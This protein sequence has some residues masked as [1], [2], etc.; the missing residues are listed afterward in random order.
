MSGT[1][2]DV[3]DVVSA[4][5]ATAFVTIGERRYSMLNAKN[6]EAKATVSNAD[7]PRLGTQIKGKKP[8]GLEIKITMTVYKVSDMF[9]NLIEEYKT[10]GVLPTFDI[11]VTSEG[12]N[13]VGRSTKIYNDC[14][15]DGDVLLSM[16]DADGEFIEQQIEAYAMD[17]ST[18][19]KFTEPAYM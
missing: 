7:V 18:A 1:F 17:Y 14:V 15:I 13:V 16:F 3:K 12:S 5:L 4:K 9:D 11:Q 8:N 2:L 19:S 6:F 10:T